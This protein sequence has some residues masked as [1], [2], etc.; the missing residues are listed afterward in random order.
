MECANSD[1]KEGYRK[2]IETVHED[3]GHELAE[4]RQSSVACKVSQREVSKYQSGCE[5]VILSFM[6]LLGFTIMV[7]GLAAMFMG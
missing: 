3:K 4:S 6:L 5:L 1:D 7:K 2:S